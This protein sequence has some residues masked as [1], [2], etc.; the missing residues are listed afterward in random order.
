MRNVYL[1]NFTTVR[2]GDYLVND[3]YYCYGDKIIQCIKSGTLYDSSYKDE[4]TVYKPRFKNNGE[5]DTNSSGYPITAVTASEHWFVD[6]SFLCGN[7]GGAASF[8]VVDTL[9]Y[10]E[11]QPGLTTNYI[12]NSPNYDSDTHIRLGKYLRWYRDVH[13]IDLTSL[14]NCF[15][16]TTTSHLHIKNK[17]IIE[18][19][20]DNL[21]VWIVP[22]ELNKK[23]TIFVN[24]TTSVS[25]TSTFLNSRGRVKTSSTTY[26]DESVT[27]DTFVFSGLT[28]N[29]PIEYRTFVDDPN[30][31]SYAN[32]FYLVIQTDSRNFVPIVVLEGEHKRHSTRVVNNLYT[33]EVPYDVN[34][35]SFMNP[36]LIIVP[37]SYYV[38][39]S[40]RLIEFL[41]EHAITSEESIQ[42]NVRRI[43]NMLNITDD[44]ATDVW[45]DKLRLNILNN[46]FRYSN[47]KHLSSSQLDKDYRPLTPVNSNGVYGGAPTFSPDIYYEL[48][49]DANN[50]PC[51]NKLSTKPVNWDNAY[52]TFYTTIERE[53]GVC[54]FINVPSSN[55][56]IVGLKDTPLKRTFDNQ[57][58]ITGFVDKDIENSL[59]KYRSK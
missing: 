38:P 31:M 6:Y 12:S 3:T 35:K 33:Q 29:D 26:L 57:Y 28:Y 22:I 8:N 54:E 20:G 59:Y 56:L 10:S 11:H 47:S 49:V 18:G 50:I 55:S 39:Y 34:Y 9:K 32:N 30:V 40:N 24:S 46:Y 52:M 25:I 36:S 42:Y 16:N 19:P 13:N 23:Y 37:T 4:N 41:T 15:C 53:N 1:P 2:P 17:E 21:N 58:D 44:Y 5:P 27:R 45:T 7:T 51:Y 14:Y 43:Q 48:T